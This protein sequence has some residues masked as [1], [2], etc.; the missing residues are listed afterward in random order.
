MLKLKQHHI[1]PLLTLLGAGPGD[2]ELISVKG[3]KAIKKA[4]VILYDNLA[5]KDLLSHAS[6]N[7][8][9]INVGKRYGGKQCS[10]EWINEQIVQSAQQH[11][12]VLRLKGGDPF[13]FGRGFEEIEVARKHGIETE[14]IPGISSSIGVPSVAGLPLTIRGVAESFWVVTG[15]TKDGNV[16]SD[17]YHASHSTATVVVLMG[18]HQLGRIVE[19]F[20][21]AGKEKQPIAI[22][23]EGSTTKERCVIGQINTITRL[24]QEHR[25]SS[26]AIIVIG[27]VVRHARESIRNVV[28]VAMDGVKMEVDVHKT[29]IEYGELVIE[30]R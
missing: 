7:C 3:L 18:M 29:E 19:T 14:I 21:L 4:R 28:A 1:K 16:S 11:G 8:L 30:H 26:P 13:I 10:Q 20:T 12:N 2:E 6:P 24:V 22:I 25:F 5:N 23:Q 27:E 15:T 17:L 9:C